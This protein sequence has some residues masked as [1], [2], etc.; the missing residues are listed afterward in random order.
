MIIKQSM[1]FYIPIEVYPGE[2]SLKE[3]K[4][5]REKEVQRKGEVRRRRIE[6]TKRRDG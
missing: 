1:K 5:G 4:Q 6:M 2:A 3:P